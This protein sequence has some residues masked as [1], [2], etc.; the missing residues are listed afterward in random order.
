MQLIGSL[1]HLKPAVT[2]RL[3]WADVTWCSPKEQVLPVIK[4]AKR[5]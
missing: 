5:S 4:V 1:M 3:Y 2:L